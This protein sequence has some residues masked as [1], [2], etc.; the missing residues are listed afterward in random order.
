MDL[1]ARSGSADGNTPGSESA[2][3]LAI[4]KIVHYSTTAVNMNVA[5]FTAEALLISGHFAILLV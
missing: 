1:R 4:S 2:Q 5:I 3:K